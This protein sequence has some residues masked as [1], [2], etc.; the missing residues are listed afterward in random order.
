MP[1]HKSQ[2]QQAVDNLNNEIRW[3]FQA[4]GGRDGTTTTITVSTDPRGFSQ[5]A[6]TF[7]P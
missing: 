6:A 5:V 3:A 4:G 1:D 7:T 2:V